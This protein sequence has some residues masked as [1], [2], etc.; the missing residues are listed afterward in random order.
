MSQHQTDAPKGNVMIV[1]DTPA[2]LRLL[3]QMLS[4]HGYRVRPVPDGALVLA[5]VRAEYPDLVLIDIRM[6]GM[7]GYEVCERLKADARTRD[8]PVIFISAI[9]AIQDKLRAFTIGGAN[10]VTKP[11]QL[12][13]VLARVQT[14]LAL[15]KLQRQLQDANKRMKQELALAGQVQRSFLPHDLP[16][17]PGWQLT[18]TL[19]PVRETSGDFYD[20]IRLPNRRLGIVVADVCD[21]G[22]GAA[23]IW[24]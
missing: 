19:K 18:A 22:A 20:F 16:R 1:D 5:A 12:E 15:R 13:E 9:D 10:Y 4:E 11:F 14:H 24:P 3:S 23:L 7:D 17:I 6:P 21:K 8:I 2:N